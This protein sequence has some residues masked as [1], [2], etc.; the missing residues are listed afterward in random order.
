MGATRRRSSLDSDRTQL[1]PT[2]C[3]AP[4]SLPPPPLGPRPWPPRR[5]LPAPESSSP[6]RKDLPRPGGS[7]PDR[8]GGPPLPGGPPPRCRPVDEWTP[9]EEGV[10]RLVREV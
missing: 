7:S 5:A 6:A 3:P 2:T 8:F 4:E 1:C 9:F 10:D